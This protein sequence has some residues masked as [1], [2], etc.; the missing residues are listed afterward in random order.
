MIVIDQYAGPGGWDHA[1]RSLGIDPLGIEWDD[2]ACATRKAAGLRTLQTDITQCWPDAFAPCD[3]LISSAPCPSFSDAGLR[4]GIDDLPVIYAE[5]ARLGRGEQLDPSIAWKD[6][7]SALVLQPLLWALALRPTKLAWEQVP[8]VLPFWEVCAEVLRG[9]GW[10]VWTGVL[11]AE[12][13]GVAQTRERAFLMAD[14]DRH[15]EPP[16]P[17]HQR[18]VKGEP[19]RHEHTLEGE[20]L[21]WVSM[22]KALGWDAGDEVGF[23]RRNDTPS[24]KPGAGDEGEY[25][26]RDRRAA[27]EPAFTLGEKA[28]SW[29][30]V[31]TGHTNANGPDFDPHA[32]PAR[33]VAGDVGKWTHD[34]PAPTITGG[35]RTHVASSSTP[36]GG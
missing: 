5:A 8:P 29:D 36:T 11:E 2:A 13:Y 26:E 18:Y 16:R 21:P 28:R 3:L 35:N 1:A 4:E 14:R 6:P 19:A 20:L 12:R 27:S 34:R 10:N 17:T 23:P 30:R 9:H 24:N 31:T 25:R 7:R 32:R 15:V 33:T 22:A